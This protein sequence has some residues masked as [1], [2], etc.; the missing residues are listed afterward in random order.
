MHHLYTSSKTCVCCYIGESGGIGRRAGFRILWEIPWGFESPLSHQGITPARSRA[1]NE[2]KVTIKETSTWQ[3]SLEMEIPRDQVEAEEKKFLDV[4]RKKVKIDGFR[5]GKAPEHVI[6]QR[7][8]DDI[9]TDA[10]EAVLP[11]VIGDAL[12]ENEFSPL[13]P[14]T[15]YELDYGETGP[16]RVKATFEVMPDFEVKGFRGLKLEKWI[17]PITERDI[18]EALESLLERTAELVPVDRP[19]EF[20]DYLL[21][22]ITKCDE[23]GTLLIGEKSPNRTLVVAREGDGAEVGRQLVG[24]SK[25]EDR[26]V[27]IEHGGDAPDAAVAGGAHRHVFMVQLNEVKEKRLPALDD[28]Y[29]RGLGDFDNLEDLRKQVRKDLEKQV[30]DEARRQMVGQAIDQ[31]IKKN[32]LEVP[33]SLVKRYLDG[34]VE[35]HR[36]AASGQP[37]DEQMIRQQYRGLAL[38]Q[39][40][41]QMLNARIAEQENIEVAEEELR[42]RIEGL[43]VNYNIKPDDAYKAFKQQGRLDRMRSEIREE[44]VVDIILGSAKIKEKTIDLKPEEGPQ[45]EGSAAAAPEGGEPESWRSPLI[46][47]ATGSPAGDDSE[48]GPSESGGSGL[49]IPGR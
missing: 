41:W 1:I 34:A 3:R 22:D 38:V 47:D 2:A 40:Q 11:R 33:E 15:I 25:G 6:L 29:A 42:N 10:I 28:E 7:H 14:P 13:A 46:L 37:V 44:K 27:V 18:N 12:H 49:I 8:G 26:R 31:L 20:G 43:A 39:L 24:L 4:Y 21:A 19:S 45:P 36:N 48:E 32:Q 23:A 35:D 30:E 5:A 17:R 9:R 16:L